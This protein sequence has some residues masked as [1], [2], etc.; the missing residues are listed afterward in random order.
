MTP[1]P[2]DVQLAFRCTR[3]RGVTSSEVPPD[4]QTFWPST[5]TRTAKPK[6]N[7]LAAGWR[8][9]S[10]IKRREHAILPRIPAQTQSGGHDTP[11]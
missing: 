7:L 8:S 3:R 2:L 5:K 11:S 10:E 1:L 4:P 9:M 6:A